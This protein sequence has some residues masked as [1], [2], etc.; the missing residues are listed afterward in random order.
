METL[1]MD[2]ILT[3]PIKTYQPHSNLEIRDGFGIPVNQFWTNLP[4]PLA[5]SIWQQSHSTT[6]LDPERGASNSTSSRK[7]RKENRQ[8]DS[9]LTHPIKTWQPHP[10]LELCDLF[11]IPVNQFWT[12]WTTPQNSI[13]LHCA[14]RHQNS[15]LNGSFELDILQNGKEGNFKDGLHP[16]SFD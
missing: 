14:P 7:D 3:H 16:H 15:I 6:K 5:F 2:F 10:N 11:G 1:R 13:I 12:N 9:I 4:T 8:I